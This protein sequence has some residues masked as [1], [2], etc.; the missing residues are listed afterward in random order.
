MKEIGVL[1]GWARDEKV[2]VVFVQVLHVDM[3][4]QVPL[5][6]VMQLNVGHS[7]SGT[8]QFR[9]DVESTLHLNWT[10]SNA[11]LTGL[12]NLPRTRLSSIGQS[13]FMIAAKL[14]E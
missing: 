6:N 13:Y 14:L 10:P 9:K 8:R 11:W 2:Y 7:S 12:Q 4:V 3:D 1:I 5:D